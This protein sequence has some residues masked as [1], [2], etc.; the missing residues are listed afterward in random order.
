MAIP[1]EREII[2]LV[3]GIECRQVPVSLSIEREVGCLES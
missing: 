1:F 2:G 3:D